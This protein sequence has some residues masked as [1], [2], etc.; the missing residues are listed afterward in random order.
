MDI[1]YLNGNYLPQQQASISIM[2]RG[3]LFGDGVYEV[4][5][6]FEGEMF[7]FEEHIQRLEQSLNA[8]LIPAPLSKQQWKQVCIEL[9]KRNKKTTG[10]QGIYLQITRGAYDTRSHAFPDN[11]QPTVVA[12]CNHSYSKPRE[13]LAKGKAA[14][15]LA[16]SRRRD[17]C[18]K[19]I[20]L[21]PNILLYN[22]ARKAGAFEAI[23]IRENRAIECTSS[24]LFV[25]KN[26]EI[27]TPPLSNHILGG[28]TR[29]LILFLAKK[30]K[31]K[32]REIDIDKELLYDADEI[33][34]TGSSKGIVPI[35]TVD[36][37]PIANGQAGPMWHK[38]MVYYEQ[39]KQTVISKIQSNE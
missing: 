19:A 9:I 31:V 16:D 26:G 2:D 32:F 23:L 18:I 5:P 20:N 24:N 29:E 30:N 39:Y 1:V 3:F 36:D 13:E 25:I 28:I 33:W 8:V 38:M 34:V 21:L 15:T 22:E 7:G 6:V 12:F 37:K 10:S 27:L 4:I 17:C 11:I 14:I 35:T